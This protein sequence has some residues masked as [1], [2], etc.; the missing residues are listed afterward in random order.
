MRK[1]SDPGRIVRVSRE[2]KV[3]EYKTMPNVTTAQLIE[4]APNRGARL[5]L[6][7][8]GLQVRQTRTGHS[9]T[10]DYVDALYERQCEVR[11]I[12]LCGTVGIQV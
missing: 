2:A 12:I 10:R 9:I 7:E 4:Q 8:T 11:A 5:R 3:S 1:A 6:H